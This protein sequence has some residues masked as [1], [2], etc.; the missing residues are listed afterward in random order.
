MLKFLCIG[1]LHMLN[2]KLKKLLAEDNPYPEHKD[3]EEIIWPQM[4]IIDFAERYAKQH[5]I[6]YAVQLGDWFDMP[7]PPQHIITLMAD[8]LYRSPLSWYIILGNHDFAQKGRNSLHIYNFFEKL[9]L[10]KNVRVFSEPT[11]ITIDSIPMFFCPHPYSPMD[12]SSS[13]KSKLCF[14]HFTVSGAVLENKRKV[15]EG[16]CSISTKMF[17]AKDYW[18]LGDIHER[19]S[20]NNRAVY[21]GTPLQTRFSE[22]E[23]KFIFEVRARYQNKTD[24]LEVE[25]S[26]IKVDLPYVLKTIEVETETELSKLDFSKEKHYYRLI[27]KRGVQIPLDYLAKN[28]RIIRA[29]SYYGNKNELQAVYE[30]RIEVSKLDIGEEGQGKRLASFSPTLGLEEFLKDKGLNESQ[31]KR[32]KSIVSKLLT[33]ESS[34]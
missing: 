1:D 26:A 14:G 2:T 31:I 13:S 16:E 29:P 27:L 28:R 3:L 6:K 33:A 12:L 17:R 24:K 7:E 15:G 18:I 19:Q 21:F 10:I 20:I 4:S 34:E 22:S 32:G 8:R 11:Q 9:N 5:G 23:N 30:E 25:H